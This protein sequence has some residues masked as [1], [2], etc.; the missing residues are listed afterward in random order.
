M[1]SSSYPCHPLNICSARA[2][3]VI[4][5]LDEKA[6]KETAEGIRKAGGYV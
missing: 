4:G 2:N 3:I 1:L 6:A 5:D